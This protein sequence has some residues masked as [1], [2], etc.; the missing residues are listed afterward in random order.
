MQHMKT[1]NHKHNKAKRRED[2]IEEEVKVL[3]DQVDEEPREWRATRGVTKF[4]ADLCEALIT[5]D[6]ALNKLSTGKLS[7]FL[8]EYTGFEIPERSTLRQYY[9]PSLYESVV[10]ALQR[11]VV[12]QTP[13]VAIGETADVEQRFN[14]IRKF[15][16][17]T[18]LQSFNN[19]RFLQWLRSCY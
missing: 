13:W 19:R 8:Q 10:T 4:R 9:I 5:S 14:A 3:Q 2:E 15:D 12:N 17:I 7:K 11:K 16:W 18:G 6:I 1:K